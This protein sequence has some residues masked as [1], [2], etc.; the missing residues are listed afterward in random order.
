MFAGLCSLRS[1]KQK[2]HNAHT[3][4]EIKHVKLTHFVGEVAGRGLRAEIEK[5][6]HSVVDSEMENGRRRVM[7]FVMDKLDAHTESRHIV[8]EAQVCSIVECCIW[9]CAQQCR[10]WDF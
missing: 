4:S 7:N 6:K 1:H 10:R 9:F 8:R 2:V 3:V 5:C